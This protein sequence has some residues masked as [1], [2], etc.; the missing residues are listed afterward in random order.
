[1]LPGNISVERRDIYD[2]V[3]T[4]TNARDTVV[5]V[6]NDSKFVKSSLLTP[7]GCGAVR[8]FSSTLTRAHA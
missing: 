5:R 4:A 7:W 6:S 3:Y 1:M 2:V 8:V